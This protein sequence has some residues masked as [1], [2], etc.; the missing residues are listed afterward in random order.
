MFLVHDMARS[1]VWTPRYDILINSVTY[2]CARFVAAVVAPINAIMAGTNNPSFLLFV[3]N[4]PFETN[5]IHR[6]C[7]S[8]IQQSVSQDEHSSCCR[9]PRFSFAVAPAGYIMKAEGYHLCQK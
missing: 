7:C 5:L 6:I 8:V 4:D 1:Y 2:L 3:C 9:I